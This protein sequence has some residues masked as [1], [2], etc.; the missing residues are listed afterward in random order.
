MN[1]A[2]FSDRNRIAAVAHVIQ[3]LIV[4]AISG[5]D[6]GALIAEWRPCET[7][8]RSDHE[9]SVVF[10]VDGF[11][12]YWLGLQYV[13]GVRNEIR[14]QALRR[15]PAVVELVPYAQCECKVGANLDAVLGEPSSGRLTPADFDGVEG[16]DHLGRFS[17]HEVLEIGKAGNTVSLIGGVVVGLDLLKPSAHLDLMNALDERNGVGDGEQVACDVVKLLRPVGARSRDGAEL[18]VAYR[19]DVDIADRL[20]LDERQAGIVGG[21]S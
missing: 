4:Q 21:R 11:S 15:V 12:H 2:L 18:A 8:T 19:P 16:G 1:L 17:Q 10:G 7:G 5:M 13:I 20:A 3:L 6:C 14:R 9:L